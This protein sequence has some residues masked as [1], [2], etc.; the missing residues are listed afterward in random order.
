MLLFNVTLFKN[1]LLGGE[2]FCFYFPLT[3]M[4][5]CMFY[6][7]SDVVIKKDALGDSV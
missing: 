7:W 1:I 4:L 6:T 3:F 2:S 5:T